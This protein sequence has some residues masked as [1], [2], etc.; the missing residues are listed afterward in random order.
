MTLKW[1][2]LKKMADDDEVAQTDRDAAAPGDLDGA[3]LDPFLD[4]LVEDEGGDLSTDGMEGGLAG[5]DALQAGVISQEQADLIFSDVDPLPEGEE[6][7]E[8]VPYGPLTAHEEVCRFKEC[9]EPP[10]DELRRIWRL[11][12]R[13]IPMEEGSGVGP[14][15]AADVDDVDAGLDVAFAGHVVEAPTSRT[16]P[17]K[18]SGVVERFRDVAKTSWLIGKAVAWIKSFPRSVLKEC[19]G[20]DRILQNIMTRLEPM[21]SWSVAVYAKEL[22]CH[23]ETLTRL[24]CLLS[25]ATYCIYNEAIRRMMWRLLE[26]YEGAGGT[27]ECYTDSCRMDESSFEVSTIDDDLWWCCPEELKSVGVDDIDAEI[28][29]YVESKMPWDS[30]VTKSCSTNGQCSSCSS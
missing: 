5:P 10:V 28:R 20:A 24:S 6:I 13:V 14:Q 22:R 9:I 16:N 15:A 19:K 27:A 11:A 25:A 2:I 26:A 7:A 8:Q 4:L 21:N 18:L 23:R 29:K 17:D 1:V 3:I 30:G 12:R